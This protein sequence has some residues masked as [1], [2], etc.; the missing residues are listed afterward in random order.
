MSTK[1]PDE[2]LDAGMRLVLPG[3]GLPLGAGW[4]WVARGWQIFAA[5]PLMWILSV[6]VILVIAIAM[7]FIPIIGQL[8]FQLL[9]PVFGGGLVAACRAIERGEEFE[10]E[11]LFA[12]FK[13]RFGPLMIVGLVF[14]IGT[15]VILL[16]FFLFAGMS[17][18]PVFVQG[19]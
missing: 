12:G 7:A 18:L 6:I 9:Q 1:A 5:A 4:D 16:V 10:I 13:H 14:L 2:R 3:R 17:L 11:H 8:V 15:V 19:D